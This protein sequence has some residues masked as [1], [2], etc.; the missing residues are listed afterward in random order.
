MRNIILT[1]LW[2]IIS[3]C[4][5]IHT[6]VKNKNLEVNPALKER[7]ELTK[8][9]DWV[10]AGDTGKGAI[11]LKKDGSFWQFG[12]VE[13]DWG[14]I[15]IPSPK[16]YTY[17]YHLKGKKIA[18][19]FK[20]A[21]IIHGG[22]TL[23]A[24]KKD[25]TLWV[26]KRG[27]YN[28]FIQLTSTHDW[29]TAGSSYEGNGCNSYEIGLKKDGSLWDLSDINKIERIGTQKGF[30]KVAFGCDTIY[31]EQKNGTIFSSYWKD[32][33]NI[34]LRK[35]IKNQ[36]GDD[37]YEEQTLVELAHLKSGVGGNHTDTAQHG[38]LTSEIKI[39]KDG[40]LWLTPEI[41]ATPEG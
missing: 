9:H 17:I 19:G 18:D 40:T 37:V 5:S 30:T 24:I 35:M 15:I 16:K 31:A 7:Q 8:S 12:K 14:Q 26:W 6:I 39:K 38:K 21:K 32:E 29:L 10:W 11:A 1:L 20:D 36:K 2:L 4:Q 3:G 22:Y 27:N 33:K 23:Y 13:F 34:D 41:K 28:E 25:G